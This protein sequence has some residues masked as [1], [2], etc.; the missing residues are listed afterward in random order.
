MTIIA[1]PSQLRPPVQAKPVKLPPVPG[2]LSSDGTPAGLF[3]RKL[4]AYDF[5]EYEASLDTDKARAHH[6]MHFLAWVICDN[7][8]NRLWQTET[9]AVAQLG[10]YDNTVVVA[11]FVEAVKVNQAATEGAVERA[12]KDSATS[13][14]DSTS[15]TSPTTS[16][17]PALVS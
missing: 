5:G 8:G 6:R 12:G 10:L 1:N 2:L 14:P 17:S 15:G 13:P 4:N 9:E 7:S 3:A 16:E 11:L